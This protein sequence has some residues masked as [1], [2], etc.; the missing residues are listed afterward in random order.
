MKG[1]IP[2]LDCENPGFTG[3]KTHLRYSFR[4]PQFLREAVY[5]VNNEWARFGPG[6]VLREGNYR[7]TLD[8]DVILQMVV[9]D[10]RL[11]DIIE[12]PWYV[13]TPP[14]THL[15]IADLRIALQI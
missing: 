12:I 9:L 13:F 7:L 4:K 11:F 3:T 15:N 2:V 5:P 10:R 8:Q 1:D 14:A 6:T